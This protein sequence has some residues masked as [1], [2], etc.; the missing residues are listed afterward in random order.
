MTT[1]NPQDG[2]PAH[3]RVPQIHAE[4]LFARKDE[5]LP[6]AEVARIFNVHPRT[7]R[8]WAKAGRLRYF[9]SHARGSGRMIFAREDLGAFLKTLEGGP[10]ASH[11]A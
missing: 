5:F 2:I 6:L 10:G 3:L 9:K 7:V 4:A 1:D 11:G 8:R